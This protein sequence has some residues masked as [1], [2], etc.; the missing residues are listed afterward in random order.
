MSAAAG[1]GGPVEDGATY[2]F[3][4]G[5]LMTA[6][7]G[8]LGAVQRAQLRLKG[9]SLGVATIAGRLINLGTYP[10]LLEPAGPDDVVHGELFRLDRPDEVMSWLDSYEG[11]AP[12]PTPHD[13][14]VR[15]LAPVRLATGGEVAAWVYRYRGTTSKFPVVAGGRWAG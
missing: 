2:L 6:A 8:R 14:Y 11:V 12:E 7:R 4:Y 13:E 15:V 1:D 3:V 10:G 5:T 9:T